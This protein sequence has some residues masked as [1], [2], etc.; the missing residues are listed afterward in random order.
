MSFHAT[1]CSACMAAVVFSA[2]AA[3]LQSQDCSTDKAEN[4]TVDL[5]VALSR[6]IRGSDPVHAASWEAC[7]QT[8]CFGQSISGNKK[9]NLAVFKTQKRDNAPNCY[10]FHCPTEGACPLKQAPGLA[11]YRIV[12]EIPKP[13]SSLDKSP[14]LMENRTFASPK[15]VMMDIPGPTISPNWPSPSPKSPTS[16]TMKI[17]LGQTEKPVG[18]I[19]GH[20]H[21][22][23]GKEANPS[24]SVNSLPTHQTVSSVT[25]TYTPQNFVPIN[26]ST[27]KL[28]VVQP[29]NQTRSVAMSPSH[30]GTTPTRATTAYRNVSAATVSPRQSHPALQPTAT[31]PLKPSSLGPLPPS[32]SMAVSSPVLHKAHPSHGQ[33]N[34]DSGTFNGAPGEQHIPSFGDRSVLLAVLLF[35]VVFLLLAQAV[36][37][38]KLLES[39]RHRRYSRLDYL[40]NGMYSNV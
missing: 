17:L 36:I 35:G 22:P 21:H 8:C 19:H 38:R 16:K 40:I 1:W 33:L 6:G 32:P 39:L 31:S 13:V 12:K 37:V 18:K 26:R 9:C 14:D 20:S 34:K 4:A 28:P 25:P 5:K 3:P 15:A 30:N 24:G 29:S 23:E 2:I 10:R 11:T 27:V 7:V